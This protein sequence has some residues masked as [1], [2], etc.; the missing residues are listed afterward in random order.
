[1]KFTAPKGKQVIFNGRIVTAKDGGFET[2]DKAF[3]DV[4]RNA[5]DVTE[6]KSQTKP[7]QPK[8]AD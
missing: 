8:K 2:E 6:V 1:M 7:S 3:I 5:R 4:L